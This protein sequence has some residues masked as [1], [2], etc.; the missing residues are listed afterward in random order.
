MKPWDL[1]TSYTQSTS[2]LDTWTVLLI[3]CKYFTREKLINGRV[4]FE[5]PVHT[6][7]LSVSC[8]PGTCFARKGVNYKQNVYGV[9]K[10]I[11]SLPICHNFVFFLSL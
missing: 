5:A 11:E 2:A 1:Q 6:L 4:A 3:G 9:T 10:V 7:N 8:K